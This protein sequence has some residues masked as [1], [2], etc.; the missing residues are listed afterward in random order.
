MIVFFIILDPWVM[1]LGGWNEP[2]VDLFN[3]QSGSV[4]L[5]KVFNK[6]QPALSIFHE[7]FDLNYDGLN[8]VFKHE[9]GQRGKQQAQK[10]S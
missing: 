10:E 6:T 9:F 8:C 1:I 5:L 2:S 7:R 4:F 3:V